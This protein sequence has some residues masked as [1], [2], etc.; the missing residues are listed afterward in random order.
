VLEANLNNVATYSIGRVRVGSLLMSYC[1]TQRLTTSNHGHEVYG[2]SDLIFVRGDFDRLLRLELEANVLIAIDQARTYHAAALASYPGIM[3]SRANYDVAQG[4]DDEARWRSGVLEQS[5]RIGGASAAELAALAC[6]QSDPSVH[7]VRAST[8]ELYGDNVS[9]PKGAVIHY[10][11][12]DAQVGPLTK[13][14]ML[15]PYADT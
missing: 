2:G 8:T 6:F 14:S 4:D 9:L 7:V 3:M 11:G 15:E 13:F 12:V 10:Q 1:G 5:W